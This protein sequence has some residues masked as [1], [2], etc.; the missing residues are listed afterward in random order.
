MAEDWSA[1]PGGGTGNGGADLHIGDGTLPSLKKQLDRLLTELESRG[2]A[3]GIRS[4]TVGTG[5]YGDFAGAREL[6]T[7]QAR[8]HQK[9][10]AFSQ[11][12]GEQIEALGIAAQ[13]SDKGFENV[14]ADAVQRLRAI[15]QN[16]YEHYKAPKDA[17]TAGQDA[18][19][20]DADEQGAY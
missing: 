19:A 14:E 18:K 8:V 4:S 10:Q 3:E 12:F 9:L 5:S 16:A 7:H 11:I 13:I 20:T 15:Q 17:P 1:D 2:V 6:A